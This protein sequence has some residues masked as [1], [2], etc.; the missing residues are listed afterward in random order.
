M[1]PIGRVSDTHGE[2]SPEM[3]GLT[4]YRM[5]GSKRCI[6]RYESPY[7]VTGGIKSAGSEIEPKSIK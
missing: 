4:N 5:Y 1:Y 7:T 2:N 6:C 3:R